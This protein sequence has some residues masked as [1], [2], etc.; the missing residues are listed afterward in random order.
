MDWDQS[1]WNTEGG[2]EE[3]ANNFTD[4]GRDQVSDEL[5]HVVVDGST[6]TDGGD[7]GGEVIVGENHIGSGFGDG[8]TGTHGN[9]DFGFF[10]GWG[11]VDTITSHG[12]DITVG[13][14][15][16][17]DFGFVGWFDS[18][19]KSGVQASLELLVLVQ[20]VEF[21]AGLNR[22]RKKIAKNANFL[23]KID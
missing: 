3:D 15:V 22:D 14:E 12:G 9:T 1:F 10:Q 18:G 6:F 13:L 21:S 23:I 2:G 20:V 17:D 4:V 19:E 7:D 8:G 5:F 16:T 11:V